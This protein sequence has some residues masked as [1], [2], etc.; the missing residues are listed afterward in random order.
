MGG[1][2]ANCVYVEVDGDAVVVDPGAEAGV[3]L[4]LVGRWGGRVGAVLLTHGHYDHVGAAAEVAEAWG[5]GVHLHEGD[6][7][8]Y[9]MQEDIVREYGAGRLC[10]DLRSYGEEMVFGAVRIRVYPTPGHSAGSVCLEPVGFG[11]VLLT[12]DTLFRGSVGRTD[13]PG[14]DEEALRRSL[15]FLVSRFGGYRLVPGHGPETTMGEEMRRNPFLRRW[16]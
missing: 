5:C 9:R 11:G 10:P 14:G 12:G 4:E 15:D 3:L 8:L 13:L 7:G 1:L 2:V 16:G 6:H